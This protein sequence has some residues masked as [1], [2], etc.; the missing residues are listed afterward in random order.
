MRRARSFEK[1]PLQFRTYPEEPQHNLFANSVP[2][3]VAQALQAFRR[4]YGYSAL[5][6]IHF[7]T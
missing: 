5:R 2:S 3:K 1:E 7:P 6:W 4:A